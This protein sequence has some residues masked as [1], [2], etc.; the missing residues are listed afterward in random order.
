[1]PLW[2]EQ[3]V[4]EYSKRLPREFNLI[5]TEIPLAKRSKSQSVEQCKDKE[6]NSILSR[7][8]KEDYLV[9]L[10][11]TGKRHDT[12]SLAERIDWLRTQSRNLTLILGGPDGLSKKCLDQADA[13]WSLSDL[14]LPH[15]LVRI[16]VAEQL[17]RVWSVL[18]QHPY[19]RD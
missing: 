9:A 15:T 3:G 7:V 5:V 4:L 1:M 6:A 12:L 8:K 10:E 14:T 13:Q 17:Y 11:V 18:N 16:L 2:V 19:H